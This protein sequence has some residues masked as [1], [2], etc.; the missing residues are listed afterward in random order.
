M[1]DSDSLHRFVF[2]D[3]P[4]RGHLVHLNAAWKALLEYRE[5]PNAIRDTLGE[6]VAASVLLAATLKFDGHLSLQ[7]RGGGPMH[8]LIAQCTSNLGVRGLARYRSDS[9][10]RNLAELSGEGQLLVSLDNVGDERRYQG[11]VPLVGE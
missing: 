5:Y 1:P 3:L 7:L 8:L 2:E 11:V 4:I 10:S 6:S 9:D